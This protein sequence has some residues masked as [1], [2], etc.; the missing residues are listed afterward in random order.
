MQAQTSSETI[1]PSNTDPKDSHSTLISRNVTV[2]GHRTSVRLEPEMWNGFT[3]IC[4]R[5]RATL[6]EVCTAVSQCKG[7]NT[8]LTAAIRVFVMAYYRAA[9]SEDGHTRAE[10]GQGMGV[11]PAVT[12]I[13]Q[14]VFMP[15]PALTT[16]N[17]GAAASHAQPRPQ[18]QS[19]PQPTTSMGYKNE[20]PQTYMT[21]SGGLPRR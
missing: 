11:G 5:E 1:A 18:S 19:S 20:M 3:E 14:K 10:H 9:A 15:S 4:R 8:S 21:G 16:A 17:G 13:A 7:A 2:A 12:K 6:H